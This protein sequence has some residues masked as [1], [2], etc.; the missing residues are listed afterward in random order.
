MT[1]A[2]SLSDRPLVTMA[3]FAFNQQEHIGEALAG[4]LSQTYEQL[5]IQI[6]DDYSSDET[7]AVIEMAVTAYTG[8]HKVSVH[9]NSE[10]L[11]WARFGQHFNSVVAQARGKLIILAAGDDISRPNRVQ[12]LV[13]AWINA[14]R[15]SCVLHSA[16]E[17]LSETPKLHGHLRCEGKGFGDRTPLETA[18]NDGEGILGA[19]TAFTPDLITKF[20]PLPEGAVFEDRTLGFRAILAGQVIYLHEPLVQYRLH[21]ANVSGPNIYSDPARWSR[22]CRGHQT[23]YASFRADYLNIYPDGGADARVLPEIERRQAQ[24]RSREK[25]L[26]GTFLQK[27]LAAWSVTSGQRN[28]MY[29]T[30]FVLRAVGLR[31]PKGTKK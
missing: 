31:K 15:P 9:R 25:L 30:L 17:T 23:L 13:N 10:N 18:L 6:F 21:S 20:G 8:P 22:F 19:T 11:G 27:A 5:E 26:T 24:L 28:W 7:L 2:A 29:R 1:I 3:V 12:K 4:A 14:G 16:Y